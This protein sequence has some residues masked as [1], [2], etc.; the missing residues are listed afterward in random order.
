MSSV[1]KPALD[2]E[3]CHRPLG[4]ILLAFACMAIAT[5]TLDFIGR[6]YD[7]LYFWNSRT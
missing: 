7:E 1:K 6:T 3:F 2:S 4:L 5:L